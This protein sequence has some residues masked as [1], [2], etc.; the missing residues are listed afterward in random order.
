MAFLLE[1]L[2]ILEGPDSE[3]VGLVRPTTTD[4][5]LPDMGTCKR[6]GDAV[7]SAVENPVAAALDPE[8]TNASRKLPI[9]PPPA[10]IGSYWGNTTGKF[11][12]LVACASVLQLEMQCFPT[13]I[14]VEKTRQ[15]KSQNTKKARQRPCKPGYAQIFM[16]LL[17]CRVLHV[18]CSALLVYVPCE[19]LASLH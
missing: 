13:G 8:G 14:V 1:K 12:H 19:A 10:T 5:A 6:G 16:P 11:I 15:H 4:I 18:N 17:L 9:T 2:H 3:L 7:K